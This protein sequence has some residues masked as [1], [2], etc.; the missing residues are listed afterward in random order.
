MLSIQTEFHTI[1]EES[2]IYLIAEIGLNHNGDEKLALKMIEEAVEAGAHAVKFQLFN[3]E[4]FID[5]RLS[6]PQSQPGSIR[7][8]FKRFE[9]P[10]Q[11]Y[12]KLAEAARELKT[13]F[14]ASVFDEDSLSFYCGELG[15]SIVKI[16]SGDL[17][18]RPLLESVRKKGLK[19]L[20]STGASNES[21]IE[22]VTQWIG[23]PEILMQ[24]VSQYPA[25][26]CDYNLNVLPVWRQKYK[27]LT[28]ISDHCLENDLTAAAAALGVCAVEKHF[29]TDRKLHGAD[30]AMSATPEVF[31]NLARAV[32]AVKDAMGDGV[33]RCMPS[34]ETVRSSARRSLYYSGSL[35]KGH[36]LT[37][38]DLIALRPGDGIEAWQTGQVTGKKLLKDVK[39]QDPVHLSDIQDS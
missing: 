19:I 25:E 33:K 23:V 2:D 9:L 32:K 1:S 7:A 5:H 27:T 30:H 39:E 24:C 10:A 12:K 35:K 20:L 6:F 38:Q 4:K 11:S 17:T 29:T 14:L 8:F 34:E 13:D 21:E 18:N 22:K 36:I 31:Q 16:A 26:P 15:G 3:S 28:G 37:G